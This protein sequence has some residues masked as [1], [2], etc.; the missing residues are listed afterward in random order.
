MAAAIAMGVVTT[1]LLA[2]VVA[3]VCV[4]W[5]VTPLRTFGA[6][7]FY[8][9][10]GRAGN[11]IL[12]STVVA[13]LVIS[14]R[15]IYVGDIA[16]KPYWGIDLPRGWAEWNTTSLT[17]GYEEVKTIGHG[18]PWRAMSGAAWTSWRD[19]PLPDRSDGLL[20]L[21]ESPHGPVAIPMR[22]I[23]KGLLAD[24]GVFSAAWAVPFVV[25]TIVRRVRRA[26]GGR[27]RRCG[28]DRAGLAPGA[29][30]PECGPP[31]VR[32]GPGWMALLSASLVLGVATTFGVAWL[33]PFAKHQ[34]PRDAGDSS[35]PRSIAR[36]DAAAGQL[37]GFG[38]R[39]EIV[40]AGWPMHSFWSWSAETTDFSSPGHSRRVGRGGRLEFGRPPAPVASVPMIPAWPGFV[41]NAGVFGVAWAG[42]LVT[43]GRAVRRRGASPADQRVTP[44]RSR[45]PG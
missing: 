37:L 9:K 21:T 8:A 31:R 41:V 45:G 22:P 39:W 23:W 2:W 25:P 7:T 42:V 33:G 5:G 12:A 4:M 27:C 11:A 10:P 20:L 19:P 24:I 29:I 43:S 28:Y 14:R 18:W 6:S 36:D 26:R 13:D 1:L 15:I 17:E 34:L 3:P 38:D 40:R 16:E 44:R 30:C 35:R 32:R